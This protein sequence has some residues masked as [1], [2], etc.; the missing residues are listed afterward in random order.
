MEQKPWLLA[1]LTGWVAAIVK[2]GRSW[3]LPWRS[4][5]TS[6]ANIMTFFVSLSCSV[7]IELHRSHC[8]LWKSWCLLYANAIIY[9]FLAHELLKEL[10]SNLECAGMVA[11]HRKATTSF[12]VTTSTVS[13]LASRTAGKCL[14]TFR[15]FSKPCKVE[16]KAWRPSSC[17][18]P[19]RP[20]AA[21]NIKGKNW[22]WLRMI[23]WKPNSQV[24]F[25]E[26]FFLLRGNHE[27]LG[28]K[29][30]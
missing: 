6:M 17:F 5:A 16:S 3:K 30:R 12:W 18:S 20:E 25:P 8:Q 4:V 14:P 22:K 24:K 27:C 10:C 9:S 1:I 29:G 15:V 23:L 11:F 7:G 21:R 19:T 13:W 26:N 2:F 28:L